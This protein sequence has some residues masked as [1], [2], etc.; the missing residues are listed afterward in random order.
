MIVVEDCGKEKFLRAGN[1][2]KE[3]YLI[4]GWAYIP[5]AD[6]ARYKMKLLLVNEK[7]KV[8]EMPIMKRYRK[9]VAAILPDEVNVEMTG[10]CCWIYEGS[11]PAGTYDIW[12]TAKDCCSRQRLYRSAGKQL[13]IEE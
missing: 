10:F 4:K 1:Q 6:N 8:W 7:G 5:G 2:G 9:D 3:Y 13:E 11:L 12:L